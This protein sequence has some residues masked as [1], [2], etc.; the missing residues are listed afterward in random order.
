[1]KIRKTI[2]QKTERGEIDPAELAAVLSFL[3]M[4]EDEFWWSM[5][6]GYEKVIKK[7]GIKA[8]KKK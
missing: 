5:K 6:M 3:K 7:R 2:R 1:M 4:T 8:I